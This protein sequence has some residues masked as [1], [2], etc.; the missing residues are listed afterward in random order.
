MV[1]IFFVKDFIDCKNVSRTAKNNARLTAGRVSRRTIAK[2]CQCIRTDEKSENIK[3]EKL[4]NPDWLESD[5]N[6]FKDGTKAKTDPVK[7]IE[8]KITRLKIKIRS[9]L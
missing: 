3:E 6:I 4:K 5:K 8:N 7:V 1:L 2:L 9:S